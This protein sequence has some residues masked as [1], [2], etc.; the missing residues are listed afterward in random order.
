VRINLI[1]SRVILQP[2]VTGTLQASSARGGDDRWLPALKVVAERVTTPDVTVASA[3]GLENGLRPGTL[4]PHPPSSAVDVASLGAA[5]FGGWG[6]PAAQSQDRSDL[7]GQRG[8]AHGHEVR[9]LLLEPLES[10]MRQALG[11]GRGAGEDIKTKEA[12]SALLCGIYRCG[13]P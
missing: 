3:A 10:A 11:A 9:R 6:M 5:V 12:S 4:L 8:V 7:T 13:H 2:L 1:G